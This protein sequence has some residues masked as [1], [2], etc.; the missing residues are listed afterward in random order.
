VPHHV[1]EEKQI[2]NC[3]YDSHGVELRIM[4][5]NNNLVA[6]LEHG[7]SRTTTGINHGISEFA[8]R[9]AGERYPILALFRIPNWT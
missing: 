3:E 5:K 2:L 4:G 1:F 7:V 6:A 8:R 9:D